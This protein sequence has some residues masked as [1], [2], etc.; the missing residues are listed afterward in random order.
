MSLG[1]FENV[2]HKIC[3]E[4]IY[5]IYMYKED[6]ALNNL[7]WLICHKTQ[8]TP[9]P[10]YLIYMFKEDLALNNLQ[11]LIC[12]KTQPTPNPI[13]LIYMYK[14]DLATNNLQ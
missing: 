11:W 5:L 6:L 4:I 13:Y 8:P 14:E 3:L 12:H 7:Q 10:I 9:N 2:I 1:L